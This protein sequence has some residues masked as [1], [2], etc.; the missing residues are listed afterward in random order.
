MCKETH[1][2]GDHHAEKVQAPRGA[3]HTR[4]QPPPLDPDPQH[5][6][7]DEHL[8]AALIELP[9]ARDVGRESQDV[10]DFR[11]AL[12]LPILCLE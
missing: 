5:T 3:A 1:W 9:K 11:G 12:M 10:V 8:A 2:L 7:V 4:H 6:I